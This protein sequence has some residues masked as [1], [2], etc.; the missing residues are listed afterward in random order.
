MAKH[1]HQDLE[2]VLTG[3]R[4]RNQRERGKINR[5]GGGKEAEE[6]GVNQ[7]EGACNECSHVKG[8][9]IGSPRYQRERV[10]NGGRLR[11]IQAP[12]GGTST[13]FLFGV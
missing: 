2:T 12:E 7:S 11:R 6:A 4:Q 13:K 3:Q 10:G 9:E 8:N 1:W 5:K